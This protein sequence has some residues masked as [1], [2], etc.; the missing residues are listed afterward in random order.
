MPTGLGR[1]PVEVQRSPL[2]SGA[3]KEEV[4]EQGGGELL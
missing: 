2:R 1:S 4:E 3:G